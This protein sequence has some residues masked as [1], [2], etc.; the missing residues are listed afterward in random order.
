MEIADLVGNLVNLL[1]EVFGYFLKI[2]L[3]LH[4][5]FGMRYAFYIV[6]SHLQYAAD[7]TENIIVVGFSVIK[8]DCHN[9]CHEV[10]SSV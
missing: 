2:L 8:R 3:R 10:S 9:F 5:W 4:P 1:D 7:D 6:V